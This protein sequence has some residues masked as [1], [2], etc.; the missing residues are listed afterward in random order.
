VAYNYS[1]DAADQLLTVNDGTSN[2]S[3]TYDLLGRTTQVSEPGGS[4]SYA[5]DANNNR[6]SMTGHGSYGTV[7]YTYDN[8]DLLSSV[9][10][11]SQTFTYSRDTLGRVT[12]LTRPN[13]VNTSYAFDAAGQVTDIRT[14]KNDAGANLDRQQYTYDQVG[15]IVNWG[16]RRYKY[17]ALNRVTEFATDPPGDVPETV[18]LQYS[19]D[20]VGNLVGKVQTKPDNT[21]ITTTYTVNAADRLVQRTVSTAPNPATLT[22]D[23]NGNLTK[24]GPRTYTWNSRD[25]LTSYKLNNTTPAVVFAYDVFGRRIQNGA[26]TGILYDGIN[27][28]SDGQSKFLNSLGLDDQLSLTTGAGQTFSYVKDHLGSTRRLTDLTGVV[29]ST[30]NYSPYGNSS[31]P[32]TSPANTANSFTYTGREEDETGLIYLRNRYYDPTLERFISD[33][34]LGDAQRYVLG[35]PLKYFDPLGLDIWV[36]HG[37]WGKEGGGEFHKSICVGTY[38]GSRDCYSFGI[39]NPDD[40]VLDAEGSIYKDT[41][42]SGPLDRLSYRKTSPDTDKKVKQMLGRDLGKKGRYSL[43]GNNCRRFSENTS[44]KID[45]KFGLSPEKNGLHYNVYLK[46]KIQGFYK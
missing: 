23:D 40:N 15:N 18:K 21:T 42:E 32:T 16:T 26:K 36:E 8:R 1:Y 2:W 39:D 19:Y 9:S 4:I 3:F 25:Q 34:P 38:G 28:I 17:D 31:S 12:K 22:Y 13:A 35:N 10:K 33:D 43:F 11:D 27:L 46:L 29:T 20:N 44:A 37:I 5:Y 30:Y 14:R 45:Q 41:S 24:F 7:N 6:T